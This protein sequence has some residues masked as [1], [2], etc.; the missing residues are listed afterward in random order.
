MVPIDYS[1]LALVR[2]V[3]APNAHLSDTD[4]ALAQAF[5]AVSDEL[6]GL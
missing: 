4:N 3:L 5:A 6:I 2:R 1:F